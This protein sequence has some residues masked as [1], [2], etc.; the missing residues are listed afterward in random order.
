MEPII[1]L[2][3]SLLMVGFYKNQ[4]DL[5]LPRNNQV[6]RNELSGVF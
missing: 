5:T 2:P 1:L 6:G 4:G 3:H